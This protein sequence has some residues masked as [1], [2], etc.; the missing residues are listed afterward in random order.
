MVMALARIEQRLAKLNNWA[1]EGATDISKEFT[2]Q[3]F[4]AAMEFV[5][6]VAALAEQQQH[7]PRILI[8]YTL[9]RLTLTTHSEHGLSPLDFDLAERIDTLI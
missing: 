6:R 8:D 2:F 4:P 9:V 5:V 1:L 7:H 3:T